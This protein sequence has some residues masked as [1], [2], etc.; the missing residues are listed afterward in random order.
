MYWSSTTFS[1][2]WLFS[3]NGFEFIFLWRDS[4]KRSIE[5]VKSLNLDPDSLLLGFV[6]S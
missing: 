2:Y 4:E 3:L 6:I 1:C 5:F